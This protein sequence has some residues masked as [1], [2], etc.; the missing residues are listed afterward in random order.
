MS[1]ASGGLLVAW[2]IVKLGFAVILVFSPIMIWYWVKNICKELRDRA[3]F[4]N[5]AIKQVQEM[6]QTLVTL[7]QELET[8]IKVTAQI[9][10]NQ[11]TLVAY[12]AQLQPGTHVNGMNEVLDVN[13]IAREV[14]AE[15]GATMTWYTCE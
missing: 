2:D 4:E 12:M 5:E 6:S 11:E 1:L 14:S 3:E 8:L 7:N 13:S 9:A 10:I 15:N